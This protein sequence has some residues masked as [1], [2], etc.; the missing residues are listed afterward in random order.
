[1][2]PVWLS[3]QR[4]SHLS[5]NAVN[6]K[7]D[8]CAKSRGRDERFSIISKTLKYRA[9]RHGTFDAVEQCRQCRRVDRAPEAPYDSRRLLFGVVMALDPDLRYWCGKFNEMS[10][11]KTQAFSR[12]ATLMPD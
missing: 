5:S 1:M 11:M 7:D 8:L 6:Q 9:P 12:V 4:K 10:K 3:P 2:I